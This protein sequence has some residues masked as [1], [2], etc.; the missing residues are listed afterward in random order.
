[1]STVGVTGAW[2]EKKKYVVFE[3]TDIF[4]ASQE[5]PTSI[6]AQVMVMV[7]MMMMMM[8]VVMVMVMMI[9]SP[10]PVQSLAGR[11]TETLTTAWIVM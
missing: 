8:T 10:C 2:K 11:L 9:R 7:M 6:I 4:V 1:M 5:T 3:I